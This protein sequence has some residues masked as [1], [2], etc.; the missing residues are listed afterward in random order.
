MHGQREYLSKKR[1]WQRETCVQRWETRS[2]RLIF[3]DWAFKKQPEYYENPL[4][5]MLYVLLW[6]VPP[7]HGP[8]PQQ[9]DTCGMPYYLQEYKSTLTSLLVHIDFL[10]WHINFVVDWTKPSYGW[11]L[12]NVSDNTAC[13]WLCYI[14]VGQEPWIQYVF[15][16]GQWSS[17]CI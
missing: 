17:S 5:V 7:A 13:W 11:R 14:F 16:P 15:F 9:M 12:M 1:V 8:A 4:I 6:P 2:M 3:I 10:V